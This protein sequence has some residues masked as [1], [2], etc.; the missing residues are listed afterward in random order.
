MT[1]VE[2][3]GSGRKVPGW[4]SFQAPAADRLEAPLLADGLDELAD[5]VFGGIKKVFECASVI[6][7]ATTAA[8]VGRDIHHGSFEPV[9]PVM[10]PAKV[11]VSNDGLIVGKAQR[12]GAS[13]RLE[14]S[15]A[16]GVRAELPGSPC[17]GPLVDRTVTPSAPWPF[18]GIRHRDDI[19]LKCPRRA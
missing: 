2:A 18:R 9:E 14:G 19:T 10:E 16:M 11:L 8:N 17:P 3:L 6:G 13:P 1:F 7:M 15:L 4:A 5:K 12:G